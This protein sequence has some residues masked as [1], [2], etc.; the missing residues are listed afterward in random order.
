MFLTCSIAVIFETFYPCSLSYIKLL[1][2]K[3]QLQIHVNDLNLG[4]VVY[5]ATGTHEL[6]CIQYREHVTFHPS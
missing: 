6:Y 4:F 2:W 1:S 3:I 5:D